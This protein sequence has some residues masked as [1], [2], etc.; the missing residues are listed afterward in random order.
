MKVLSTIGILSIIILLTLG[1]CK[2]NASSFNFNTALSASFNNQTAN[3]TAPAGLVNNTGGAYQISG[4][5]SNMTSNT[6]QILLDS[7]YTRIDT[8]KSTT[9]K[10]LTIVDGGVTYS[11]ST[12]TG[13]GILNL[14]VSGKN[15]TGTFNGTLNSAT[16]S[17]NVTNGTLT[18]TY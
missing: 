2:K 7:P 18:T 4:Y 8:L 13:N 9:G 11:T 6:I 16:G 5:E 12:G 1:A 14:T 17:I 10:S 3:Y 15:V